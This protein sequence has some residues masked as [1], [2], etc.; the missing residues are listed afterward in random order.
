MKKM[1]L[2]TL[3][4]V[5]FAA[6]VHASD[7]GASAIRKVSVADVE[8]L[9]SV[10]ATAEEMVGN[11]PSP[12]R[13]KG[14]ARRWVTRLL[15]E[16]RKAKERFVADGHERSVRKCIFFLLHCATAVEHYKAGTPYNTSQFEPS[17]KFSCRYLG[18]IP[19]KSALKKLIGVALQKPLP[20]SMLA[21]TSIYSSRITADIDAYN[22]QFY[23]FL[24]DIKLCL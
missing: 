20:G 4:M 23:S 7:D 2:G 1:T 8:K 15:N 14:I 13:R 16:A 21:Q 5:F 9:A 11:V 12:T 18:M 6:G 10:V 22:E 19:K 3:L 24:D 17:G